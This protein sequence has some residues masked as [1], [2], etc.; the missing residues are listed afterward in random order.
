M[1]LEKRELRLDY[2]Q[3]PERGSETVGQI[4]PALHFTD[5]ETKS[6]SWLLI[7]LEVFAANTLGRK[8]IL[9]N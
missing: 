9:C 1:L 5:K 2:L 6:L 7:Q 4:P 3:N 8:P